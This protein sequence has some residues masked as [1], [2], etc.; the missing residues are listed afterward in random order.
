MEAR[1]VAIKDTSEHL[2]SCAV[3]GSEGHVMADWIKE[4]ALK[5]LDKVN[6]A[7][8]AIGR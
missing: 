4:Q 2:R 6:G 3:E 8:S 5:W 1:Y 7:R